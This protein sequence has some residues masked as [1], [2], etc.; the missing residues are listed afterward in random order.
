MYSAYRSVGAVDQFDHS[1]CQYPLRFTNPVDGCD[2]SDPADPQCTNKTG[3]EICPSTVK[4]EP[5]PTIPPIVPPAPLYEP[6][7]EYIP[8]EQGK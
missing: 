6:A 4:D 1:L 3:A 2:N 5:A 7:I 8:P